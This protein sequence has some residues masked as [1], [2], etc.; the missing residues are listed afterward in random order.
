L[1][2]QCVVFP[3][4]QAPK[5]GAVSTG[6]PL[7]VVDDVRVWTTTEK[8]K[9]GEQVHKDAAGNSLGS[10]DVYAERTRVHTAKVFPLEETGAAIRYLA[11]RKAIG[12][13]L[14]RP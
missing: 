8:E 12:K 6:E 14:V 3:S 5:T 2:V 7:G 9:V 13:V 10:T 11:D 4:A 1:Y